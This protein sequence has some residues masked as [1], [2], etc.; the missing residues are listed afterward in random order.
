[1]TLTLP[2]P[3]PVPRS[4]LQ[5]RRCWGVCRY[6]QDGVAGAATLIPQCH[7]GCSLSVGTG[8]R[9]LLC[10]KV[11]KTHG[12]SLDRALPKGTAMELLV[13]AAMWPF[14]M[15]PLLPT[16]SSQEMECFLPVCRKLPQYL[17]VSAV[18]QPLQT[19]RR[20][21]QATCFCLEYRRTLDTSHTPVRWHQPRAGPAQ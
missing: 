9:A 20:S 18:T 19:Q 2:T 12:S 10:Q 3:L 8:E 13:G 4:A 16:S 21:C 11:T 6:L 1:M 14:C 5:N 15:F 17:S 7:Q